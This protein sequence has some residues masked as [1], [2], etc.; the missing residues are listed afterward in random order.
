MKPPAQ[1][2]LRAAFAP[3]SWL[4]G[5]W[6]TRRNARYDRPGWEFV[7]PTAVKIDPAAPSGATGQS[8]AVILLAPRQKAHL[9]LKPKARDVTAED[10][11]FYVEGANLYLPGPGVIDGRFQPIYGII[12]SPIRSMVFMIWAWDGPPEWACLS[13]SRQDSAPVASL[14]R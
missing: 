6:I 2:W 1:P 8:A 3:L 13:L 12:R 5:A 9:A 4:Y 10:T 7:S 14:H 11:R